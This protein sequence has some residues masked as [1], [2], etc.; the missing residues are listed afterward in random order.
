MLGQ[1][2]I[3]CPRTKSLISVAVGIDERDF[4]VLPANESEVVCPAC[5]TMHTWSRA[6]AM[7]VPFIDREVQYRRAG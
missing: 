7:F 5:E 3:R 2:L 4:R 1:I 6:D